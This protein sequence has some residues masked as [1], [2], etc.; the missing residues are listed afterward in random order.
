[1]FNLN[2][3]D[4]LREKFPEDSSFQLIKLSSLI[5]GNMDLDGSINT[6]SHEQ[7]DGAFTWS[8]PIQIQSEYVE[9]DDGKYTQIIYSL[10]GIDNFDVNA[11]LG[12]LA[13]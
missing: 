4:I 7:K 11:E 5:V 10:N 13:S 8:T 3:G 12:N 6:C 1:M 9:M 2:N